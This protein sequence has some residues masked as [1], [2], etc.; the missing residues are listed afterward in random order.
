M[1]IRPGGPKSRRSAVVVALLMLLY[2]Q[3]K[4]AAAVPGTQISQDPYTSSTSQHQTETEPESASFGDSVL[5]VFQAGRFPEG[6]GSAN[7]GWAFSQDKGTTWESGF[8]PGLTSSST[9]LGPADRATNATAAY[10][11]LHNVWLVASLTLTG[12]AGAS[13]IVVSRSP[14]GRTW[15]APVNVSPSNGT[16]RHDKSWIT[17][18]NGLSS[19]F[20]G[21]CY[22]SWTS[23]DDGG[24]LLTSWSS[25]GGRS[26]SSPVASSDGSK[27]T[28]AQ[29]VVRPD[30][31]LVVVAL[32]FE[33]T[34]LGAFSS[35]D[36]GMSFGPRV[37]IS[38]VRF[39][40]IAGMRA[41]PFPSAA[42][43]ADG[44]IFVVWSDC[45]FRTGCPQAPNDLVGAASSD[46][47]R[48]SEVS[49]LPVSDG[50]GESNKILPA[51]AIDGST[52]ALTY[53]SVGDGGCSLGAGQA[54]SA[55][56]G[57][58]W[59]SAQQLNPEPMCLDW[60]PATELGRMVGDYVST[61]IAGSKAVS[62][63]PRASA[64]PGPGRFSQHMFAASMDLKPSEVPANSG[65]T[66]SKLLADLLSLLKSAAP[67]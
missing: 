29:P 37:E 63:Y 10:D 45:R 11:S 20:R 15:Q 62:V 4:G 47:G 46:G 17:C 51:L 8:L 61:S 22:V 44:R 52:Q 55:D 14:D 7:I 1:N 56:G 59:S 42:V 35:A 40:K 38:K 19:P 16:F 66:L 12:S 60:L 2:F 58:T 65:D 18:D 13:A 6:G 53:Y 50:F 39:T 43:D 34:S 3:A 21:R 33:M 64:P 41:D 48:W 32:D 27:G 57:V 9:P 26:W 36:G 30:G 31:S 23:W 5:A 54:I 25:D 24:T 49:R 67:Q 28:G